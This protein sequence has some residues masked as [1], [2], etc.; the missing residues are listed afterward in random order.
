MSLYRE[1]LVF[2]LKSGALKELQS[3]KTSVPLLS[4]MII[5]C[6]QSSTRP[7][8]LVVCLPGSRWKSDRKR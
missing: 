7:F 6:M 1:L 5:A 2:E 4:N 3:I 8:V